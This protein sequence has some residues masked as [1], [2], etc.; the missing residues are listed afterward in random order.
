MTSADL[1]SSKS[2]PAE[3]YDEHFVPALFGPWG[4]RVARLA[5]VGPG[6]DVLDV[7]C[8]TGALARAVNELVQPGGTVTGL[9]AND[10]MLAVAS[11]RAPTIKWVGGSAEAL[12]FVDASFDAV[13]SQ[14]ALM[15]F[16]DKSEAISEMLRVLRP[17]GRLT[18][19]VWDEL[20]NATGFASLTRLLATL[21][22]DSVAAAMEPPFTLGDKQDLGAVFADAGLPGVTITTV[23]GAAAYPSIDAMIG[24]ERACIWTLG[25]LLDDAQFELLRR[26]ARTALD[27]FV[28]ADGSVMFDVPAHVVSYVVPER[29]AL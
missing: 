16:A 23:P 18:V 25:G 15:F 12:P 24:A 21:F 8:G 11:R 19:A 26:E 14:A 10:E 13:V 4:E 7:A 28:Q 5:G 9:D 29:R 6:D 3:S 2:G 1:S 27:E 17:G 20:D 22:G